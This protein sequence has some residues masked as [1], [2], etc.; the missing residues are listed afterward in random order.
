MRDL[1]RTLHKLI[2]T[3]LRRRQRHLRELLLRQPHS[4]RFGVLSGWVAAPCAPAPCAPTG[5]PT[6]NPKPTHTAPTIVS[7]RMPPQDAPT[8]N[9][10]RPHA[11]R[12]LVARTP[13]GTL[14]THARPRPVL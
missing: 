9:S 13:F 3:R 11:S 4:A 10:L 12:Q 1:I 6:A 2:Q 14:P 8:H 5:C 7:N